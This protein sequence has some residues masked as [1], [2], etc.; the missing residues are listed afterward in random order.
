MAANG[1]PTQ[2]KRSSDLTLKFI[3]TI[4]K[5][6][7]STVGLRESTIGIDREP[8]VRIFVM[9][10]GDAHQTPE[11]R[12]FVGGHWRD[13]DE[14]P[15]A[16]T[17][18]TPYYLHANGLLSA[19]KPANETP[20]TYQF[21]PRHPVPT[22]GRKHRG[23][24]R[25]SLTPQLDRA[26][27]RFRKPDGAGPIRSTVPPR[28]LVL[29]GQPSTFCPKRCA[30][31]PDGA[32]EQ[33]CGSDGA[34]H[35]EVVGSSNVPDTDFTAKLVDVYPPNNDFPAGFDLNVQDGIIRA[36]YRNSLS[37]AELMKPGEIYPHHDG[38]VP[39]FN[40]LSEGPPHSTGYFQ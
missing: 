30:G 34:A 18:V 28:A 15:L 25:T 23:A 3:L 4:F 17:A 6:A 19:Q 27:W 38:N 22:L 39:Y 12:I 1:A 40:C 11:G 2:A 29:R 13:E 5:C 32:S 33:R 14:W 26:A 10:G 8:P 9:G 7:G 35:D 24:F 31:V 20:I 37:H 21:D 36:R 16:R